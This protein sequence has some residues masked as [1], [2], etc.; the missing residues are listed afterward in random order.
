MKQQHELQQ[1]KP[2]NTL[3]GLAKHRIMRKHGMNEQE[4][5]IYDAE[6]SIGLLTLR[7]AFPTQ[8][9]NYSD[10][11]HDVLTALWLEIFAE[12]EPGLLREAIMRFVATELKGFFPSPGQIMSVVEEIQGERQRQEKAKRIAQHDAYL[13]EL[14]QRIDSCENCSTCRFCEHREVK[15]IWSKENEMSLFC[16]NPESYRYDD[17][18]G[19]GTSANILCDHYEQKNESGVFLID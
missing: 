13:Q 8:A 16:R 3:A 18:D 19:Y 7:T 14:Q 11:E 9:R 10:R 15:N 17:D 12:V 6:V 2:A 4:W 1:Y 5:A